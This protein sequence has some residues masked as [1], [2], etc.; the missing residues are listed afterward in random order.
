MSIEAIKFTSCNQSKTMLQDEMLPHIHSIIS[1]LKRW[2]LGTYQGAVRKQ[3]LQAYL[4][5]YSFRFKRRKS[6][7]RG[8]LFYR[9]LDNAVRVPTTTNEEMMGHHNRSQG[10]N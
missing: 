6:E 3:H 4:E 2:R 1:L 5:E 8:L 10:N 9:L 7:K